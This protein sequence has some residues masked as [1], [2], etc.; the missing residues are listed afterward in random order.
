MCRHKPP[1]SQLGADVTDGV[2]SR[3]TP[4]R[5]RVLRRLIQTQA[6]PTNMGHLLFSLF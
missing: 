2:A 3:L 6:R 5:S 4:V 1:I